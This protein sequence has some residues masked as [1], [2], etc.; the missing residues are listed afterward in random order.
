MVEETHA[1]FAGGEPDILLLVAVDDAVD[2]A[3]A[4]AAGLAARD[5]GAGEILKFEGDVLKDVTHPGPLPH[6]LK[7][8]AGAAEGA[9]VVVERREKLGQ[10]LVKTGDLV[11]WAVFEFANVDN[12]QDHGHPRPDVGAAVDSGVPHL[13]H[14]VPPAC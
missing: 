13:D 7:E 2:A 12:H 5:L 8:T 1:E 11:G 10:V 14:R 3:L 9:A 4:G 6:P